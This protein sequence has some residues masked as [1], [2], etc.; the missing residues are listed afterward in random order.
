MFKEFD[1]YSIPMGSPSEGLKQNSGKVERENKN[2]KGNL[3]ESML[4][5]LRKIYEFLK[6]RKETYLCR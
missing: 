4:L 1:F 6:R 3:K 2:N 5:K